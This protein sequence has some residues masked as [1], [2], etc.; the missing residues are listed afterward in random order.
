M[1]LAERMG[2]SEIDSNSV[3]EDELAFVIREN[4][5]RRW[6]F[7][8]EKASGTELAIDRDRFHSRPSSSPITA[9]RWSLSDNK[10]KE[11]A[12]RFIE[13]HANVNMD[14]VVFDRFRRFNLTVGKSD[15]TWAEDYI[16]DVQAVFRRKINGIPVIGRGSRI[17]VTVDVNGEVC[18]Y[19]KLWREID[20]LGQAV[21]TVSSS[22][23]TTEYLNVASEIQASRPNVALRKA[24][25]GYHAA[26]PLHVQEYLLP[27]HRFSYNSGA[28]DPNDNTD[29][30]KGKVFL[31]KAYGGAEIENL[32]GV[33]SPEFDAFMSR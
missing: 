22:V 28:T 14:E 3:S 21:E 12:L 4:A 33:L 5:N 20:K 10:I 16:L 27:A 1:Q 25:F 29:G 6:M 15:G 13:E 24:E 19:H 23:A 31:T 17:K 32:Q 18:G 26:G 9:K 11:I 2:F 30:T 7:M 8:V